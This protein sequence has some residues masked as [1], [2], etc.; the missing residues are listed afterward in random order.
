MKKTK[1][2]LFVFTI[3]VPT[4]VQPSHACRELDYLEAAS[5]TNLELMIM[6]RKGNSI[7]STSCCPPSLSQSP[8]TNGW[9]T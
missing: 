1:L 4:E 9:R 3:D 7:A 6:K 8:R 2:L 5:M